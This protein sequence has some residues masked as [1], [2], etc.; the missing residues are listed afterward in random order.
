M[1]SGASCQL[2]GEGV[3]L[4]GQLTMVINPDKLPPLSTIQSVQGLVVF[5]TEEAQ[6]KAVATMN[7]AC[8]AA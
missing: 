4:L 5:A 7:E 3:W 8:K 1:Y 6:K 2:Q